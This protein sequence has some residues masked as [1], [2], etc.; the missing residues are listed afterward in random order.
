MIKY[1]SSLLGLYAEV[2]NIKNK[3]CFRV[4]SSHT[5]YGAYETSVFRASDLLTSTKD[6]FAVKPLFIEYA[7]TLEEAQKSLIRTAKLFEQLS[8]EFVIR[9]NNIESSAATQAYR[10]QK[11]KVLRQVISQEG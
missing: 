10:A 2:E 11:V 1:S 8:P 9:K 5:P 7:S 6:V 3:E 4:T